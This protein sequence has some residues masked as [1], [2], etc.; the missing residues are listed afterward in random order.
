MS[1]GGEITRSAQAEPTG[2]D[3]YSA[4]ETIHLSKTADQILVIRLHRLDEPLQFGMDAHL[5]WVTLWKQIHDDL[6]VR[7]VVVTGTGDAFIAPGAPAK[8]EPRPP[9]VEY[10]QRIMRESPDH[11]RGYLDIPVPVICALNGPV[12]THPEFALL[13]DVVFATPE[14]TIQD[15]SHFPAQVIPTDGQHAMLSALVGQLRANYF[16][17]SDQMLSAANALRWGLVNEVMAREH[18]MGRALQMARWMM[19]QPASNLRY[20]RRVSIHELRRRMHDIVELGLAYEGLAIMA[21]D[22]TDWQTDTRGLPPL[23]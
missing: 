9:L 17:Y 19:K 7:V 20:F 14:T 5:E 16:F 22:F 3:G 12:A 2:L 11:I 10:W 13:A 4:F 23:A 21:A 6:D 15:S 8:K 18:L 1:S